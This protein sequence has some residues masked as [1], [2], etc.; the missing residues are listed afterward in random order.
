MKQISS[1]AGQ[2]LAKVMVAL[3]ERTSDVDPVQLDEISRL[4]L[5]LGVELTDGA[6]REGPA[7]TAI[8][9]FDGSVTSLP[10]G[11]D[12][13]ELS[14]N[15]PV[16]VLKSFPQDLTF[17]GRSTILI[18][19][20]ASRLGASGKRPPALARLGTERSGDSVASRADSPGVLWTPCVAFSASR[21]RREVEPSPGR[22]PLLS[23]LLPTSDAFQA[24]RASPGR[25]AVGGNS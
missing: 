21:G 11:F 6:P 14:P 20:I 2:T 13:S 4:A 10:G 25:H 7:A 17:V 15:S 12:T 1:R 22:Y 24:R 8:W 9:L 19:G 18:K 23:S 5:E 3:N 16:K